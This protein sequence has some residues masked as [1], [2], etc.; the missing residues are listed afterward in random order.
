MALLS[1]ASSLATLL[2]SIQRK[3]TLILYYE[4]SSIVDMDA[5]LF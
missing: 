5:V 2:K 4:T 3:D 1:V